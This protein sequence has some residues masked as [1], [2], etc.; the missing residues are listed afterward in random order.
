MAQTRYSSEEDIEREIATEQI[1]N[2]F[3]QMKAELNNIIT[4]ISELEVETNEHTYVTLPLNIHFPQLTF[5]IVNIFIFC[6]II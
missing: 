1:I 3:K 6:Y 5:T 2:T 4:K